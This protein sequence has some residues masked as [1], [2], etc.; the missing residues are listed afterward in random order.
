MYAEAMLFVDDDQSER[1]EFDALLKQ[2]MSAD[3][4]GRVSFANTLQQDAAGFA[5]L[6]PGEERHGHTQAFEPAPKILLMLV[7]QKFGRR[8]QRHLSASLYGLGRGQRRNQGF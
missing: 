3:D 7:G 4:D 5:G 1:G 2:G 8:H 6:P